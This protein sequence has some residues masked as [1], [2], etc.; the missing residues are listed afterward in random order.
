MDKSLHHDQ[1]RAGNPI[2]CRPPTEVF[3]Y[4]Q[5]QQHGLLTPAMVRPELYG[6]LSVQLPG[7][8]KEHEYSLGSI[9]KIFASQWLSDKQ[10]VFGT[11]CNKVGLFLFRTYVLGSQAKLRCLHWCRSLKQNIV[12]NHDD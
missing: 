2:S 7:L 10:V 4:T 12:H 5:A 1:H 8:L 3:Y 6:Y 11:K 9:N